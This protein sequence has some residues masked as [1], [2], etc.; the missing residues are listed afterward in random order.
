MISG[1][2]S[3]RMNTNIKITG[4]GSS[5]GGSFQ[6]VKIIGEGRIHSDVDSDYFKCV[7]TAVVNGQLHSRK[8]RL[9]GTVQ[10][11][12]DITGN[13]MKTSGDLRTEGN[14][15]VREVKLNGET[16]VKRSVQSENFQAMGTIRVQGDCNAEKLKIKGTVSADGM[17]N[18]EHI[19]IVLYGPCNAAEIGGHSITIRRTFV[20]SLL[21]RLGQKR[22]RDL[23]AGS[24][25]GDV[26]HLEYTEAKV[27]RG[28][29]VYIGPGCRIGL[30]EYS[31]SCKSHRDAEIGESIQVRTL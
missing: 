17:L 6:N 18:A 9:I 16:F 12:G 23:T 31:E 13:S 25:E 1:H 27:V 29:E 2:K 15:E 5:D 20:S 4:S 10:V 3:E 7:G 24:I 8:F 30:V 21:S 19:D 14:L 26:L 22:Q 11:Q 28:R